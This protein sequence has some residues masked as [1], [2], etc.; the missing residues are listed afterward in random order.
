MPSPALRRSKRQSIASL[1]A[2]SSIDWRD[3]AQL[4][5]LSTE[6]TDRCIGF[7]ALYK[8]SDG[9]LALSRTSKAL[10]SI[11]LRHLWRRLH[12]ELSEAKRNDACVA[13]HD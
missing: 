6:L 5:D 11:A 10:R 7:V 1:A 2:V 4:A 9:L 8:A 12:Y 13:L 3:F